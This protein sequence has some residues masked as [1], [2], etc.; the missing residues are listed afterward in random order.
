MNCSNCGATVTAG[1][2]PGGVCRFCGTV[3]S[4]SPVGTVGAQVDQILASLG[5]QPGTPAMSH[6]QDFLRAQQSFVHGGVAYRGLPE[7]PPDA[8]RAFV[9]ALLAQHQAAMLARGVA[10]GLGTTDLA[11]AALGPIPVRRRRRSGCGCFMAVLFLV[12]LGGGFYA[13]MMFAPR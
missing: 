10:A 9:L 3:L 11:Q 12:I 7:M 13:Y 8:R 4:A 1:E 6:V 5:V 2:V